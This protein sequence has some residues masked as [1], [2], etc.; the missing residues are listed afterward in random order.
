VA[1]NDTYTLWSTEE[2]SLF[3][4][5]SSEMNAN[6]SLI[7]SD[8]SMNSSV[9]LYVNVN[10]CGYEP[11]VSCTNFYQQ[12]GNVGIS[13]QCEVSLDVDPPIVIPDSPFNIDTDKTTLISYLILSLMPLVFFFVCCLYV[14]WR[15]LF[16]QKKKKVLQLNVKKKRI[17]RSGTFYERR[18]KEMNMLQEPKRP[19]SPTEVLSVRSVQS[20]VEGKH[21]VPSNACPSFINV[22]VLSSAA[23][24]IHVSDQE[25]FL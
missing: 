14:Y 2:N 9:P 21:V 24:N 11:E 15:K 1:D 4:D 18:V 23:T 10:G 5:M 19:D 6:L 3:T 7:E 25:Q 8:D 13:F 22:P 20:V 12:Y 17:K 16:R